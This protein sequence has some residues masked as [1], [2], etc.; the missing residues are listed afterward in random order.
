[1]ASSGVKEEVA[2]GISE[3]HPLEMKTA[4]EGEL[5]TAMLPYGTVI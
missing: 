3:G 4:Y 5:C 1:M 2:V